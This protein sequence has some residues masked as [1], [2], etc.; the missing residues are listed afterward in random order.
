MGT[1]CIPMDVC[2]ETIYSCRNLS[3]LVKLLLHWKIQDSHI[4]LKAWYSLLLIF[5]VI[6]KGL[7]LLLCGTE[8][9]ILFISFV[10]YKCFHFLLLSFMDCCLVT[11]LC[12]TLLRPCG[13]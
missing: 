7:I 13:L 8:P 11:K 2:D 9:E 10:S 1:R 6:N 5:V 3:K 4:G 12:L